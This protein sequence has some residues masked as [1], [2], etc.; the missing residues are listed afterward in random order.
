LAKNII[1][2]Y[3]YK[4]ELV[5]DPFMGSGTTA[6]VC[7]ELNRN[8]IGSEIHKEYVELSESRLNKTIIHDFF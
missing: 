3:S 1:K 4:D 7:E 5:Y 2:Y 6:V 8:F